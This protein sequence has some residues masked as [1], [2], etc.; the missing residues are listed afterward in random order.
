ML[1]PAKKPQVPKINSLAGIKCSKKGLFP[2]EQSLPQ[3]V[4]KRT[5]NGNPFTARADCKQR[6]Q[7]LLNSDL[8][9]NILILAIYTFR[10]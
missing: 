3:E 7:K 1:L 4:N 6:L 9:K 5:G 10:E 2:E 8:F